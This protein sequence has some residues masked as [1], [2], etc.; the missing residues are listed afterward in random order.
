LYSEFFR[1]FHGSVD[2]I[3]DYSTFFQFFLEKMKKFILSDSSVETF[4]GR[5]PELKP[6]LET[7][8]ERDNWTSD[9]NFKVFKS[10][11]EWVA[12]LDVNSLQGL[13]KFSYE[14]LVVLFSL[15]TDRALYLF[16]LLSSNNPD[17]GKAI[18]DTAHSLSTD[19]NKHREARVMLDRLNVIQMQETLNTVF[20]PDRLQALNK[21][22][23][24]VNEKY[25]GLA[26]A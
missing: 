1:Y 9:D 12:S 17:L 14:I 10:V 2:T 19:P 15:K 7:M 11:S 5:Y 23:Q 24:A 25:G 20:L 26:D 6:L 8:N 16:N 18:L 13:E 22:M 21:A 4:W 3:S